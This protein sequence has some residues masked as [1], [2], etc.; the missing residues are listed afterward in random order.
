MAGVTL[1]VVNEPKFKKHKKYVG[2]NWPQGAWERGQ[3]VSKMGVPVVW[4][5][6]T[7]GPGKRA[8]RYRKKL[9]ADRAPFIETEHP[10][11]TFDGY[12]GP[13]IEFITGGK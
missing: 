8:E 3:R 6:M 13:V 9:V 12:E 1:I 2:D 5:T 7:R 10:P 11:G 4:D